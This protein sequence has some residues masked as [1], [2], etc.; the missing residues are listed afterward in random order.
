VPL[1]SFETELAEFSEFDGNHILGLLN[2]I[3]IWSIIWF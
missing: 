1:L 3:M 2:I